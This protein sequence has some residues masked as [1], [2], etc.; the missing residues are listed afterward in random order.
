MGAAL[1]VLG[2]FFGSPVGRFAGVAMLIAAAYGYGYYKGD[3]HGD[4]QCADAALRAK[5]IRQKLEIN[6]A[7]EQA[8]AAQQTATELETH[9]KKLEGEIDELR[10]KLK[11]KPGDV[12]ADG[13]LV[14]GVVPK[15]KPTR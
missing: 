1:S 9:S 4:R 14:P 15:P 12:F 8:T 3:A 6:L 5:I 2:F 10:A 13:C 11:A 7:K